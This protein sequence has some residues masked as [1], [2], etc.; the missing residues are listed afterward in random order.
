MK[1]IQII[2]CTTIAALLVVNIAWKAQQLAARH[3]VPDTHHEGAY[4]CAK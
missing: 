4:H 2:L 3:C 1:R